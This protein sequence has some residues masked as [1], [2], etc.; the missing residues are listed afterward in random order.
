MTAV[1]DTLRASDPSGQI[2]HVL[3][4]PDH[5]RDA[6]WRVES[7]AIAPFSS[8]GL[9]VAGMGGSAIG[10]DLA[11]VAFGARLT[12][13]L[14]V[15][16]GYE[17]PAWLRPERAVLCSSYSGDTEETLAC[18]EATEALGTRRVVATAGGR[19]A[20]L[21]RRDGVPVIG[22]P[23]GFQP[24]AA[25]GYMFVAAAEVAA[26]A[27]VADPIRTEI[28]SS[29][30]HLEGMREA[31]LDRAAGIAAQLADVIPIVYG[32]DL[33]APVAY[34]WKC[35][36]NE[37]AK[38]P[39]FSH[40]LP[41]ADHN[42]I[43]GW[44]GGAGRRMAAVFL[45]DRDQ[46]PRVRRRLEL[47]AEAVAEHATAVVHL[48]TEGESRTERLLWAVLLG[49]LVSLHLAARRGVDPGPVAAIERLKDELGSP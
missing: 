24:R 48:E 49:D 5:L 19:L 21:A 29:A 33:T 17:L 14:V 35:Q 13:P 18:Y 30:A 43:A 45:A 36:V 10:A 1:L 34:R 2:D 42:E 20:D 39:A 41:E 46:H 23:A 37:N 12:A 22:L 16:R 44:D 3:G 38:L 8:T 7:T 15:A 26:L 9:V 25:V 32:A 6:L 4:L 40:S 27:G 28:D 47:T 11:A 31:L